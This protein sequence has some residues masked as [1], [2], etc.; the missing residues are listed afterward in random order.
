MTHTGTGSRSLLRVCRAGGNYADTLSTGMRVQM[1]NLT[2]LE[3]SKQRGEETEKEHGSYPSLA[4]ADMMDE[5]Y[6]AIEGNVNRE[7]AVNIEF[8][9][10]RATL[11]HNCSDLPAPSSTTAQVPS[12]AKLFQHWP[13]RVGSNLIDKILDPGALRS[14]TWRSVRTGGTTIDKLERADL[15]RPAEVALVVDRSLEGGCDIGSGASEGNTLMS[16]SERRLNA[17]AVDPRTRRPIA[18]AG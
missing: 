8:N 17:V 12:T 15:E 6:V 11:T 3:S 10:K 7:I 18:P 14:P 4:S 16:G 13:A 9:P 5:E 1:P 2:G